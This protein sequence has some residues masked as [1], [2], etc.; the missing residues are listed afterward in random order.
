MNVNE[1]KNIIV[2]KELTLSESS[3]LNIHGNEICNSFFRHVFG[4]FWNRN[5]QNR[6]KKSFLQICVS[7]YYFF[8]SHP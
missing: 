3:N 1:Q 5:N 6:R 8:P 2:I 7:N 4:I